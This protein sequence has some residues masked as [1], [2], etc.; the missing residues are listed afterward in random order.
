MIFRKLIF[1]ILR[2]LKI[3][4]YLIALISVTLFVLYLSNRFAKSIGS[5]EI[6]KV[7]FKYKLSKN[8]LIKLKTTDFNK[9]CDL[10]EE[11][12][13]LSNRFFFKKG[14]AF[15]I[16]EESRI[17]L[18]Y[19]TKSHFVKGL[20]LKIVIRIDNKDELEINALGYSGT[21]WFV[22]VY[23]SCV[24]DSNFNLTKIIHEQKNIDL[25][26]NLHRIKVFIFV[27]DSLRNAITNTPMELK[28]KYLNREKKKS[29]ILCAKCLYLNANEYRYLNWWIELN[30]RAGYEKIVLCNQS[31]ESNH[32][33]I[34][35]IGF[36]EIIQSYGDFIELEQLECIPNFNEDIKHYAQYYDSFKMLKMN[37]HFNG[38]LVETINIIVLGE[39]YL[40]NI[41]KYEYIGV[42]D[43]DETVL[44]KLSNQFTSIS[45][46]I[47]LI[48]SYKNENFKQSPN[49]M[50]DEKCNRFNQS[51]HYIYTFLK[52]IEKRQ[53]MNGR[54]FYFKQGYLISFKMSLHILDQI[55]DY[56]KKYSF[57]GTRLLINVTHNEGSPSQFKFNKLMLTIA[58]KEEYDYSMGL[59][60]IVNLVIKP[61]LEE[62]KE[63][64]HKYADRFARFFIYLNNRDSLGK[65]IHST[66][67]TLDFS[68]H[69]PISYLKNEKIEYSEIANE[70]GYL[71]HFRKTFLKNFETMSVNDLHLDLNYF[72]CY[73]KPILES[74]FKN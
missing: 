10:K 46:S 74:S 63:I 34:Y 40:N 22:D 32:K 49:L 60:N 69:Q 18:F 57:N 31:L 26:K 52:D 6:D 45:K 24:Y 17:R 65:T 16:I 3:L 37:G 47:K 21:P 4:Y 48:K 54:S 33:N 38:L 15:Y 73:F 58:D 27:K 50:S 71:S 7:H 1:S 43:N 67:S 12:I 20:K 68:V 25:I 14:A 30:Q 66:R 70:N 42:F 19:L 23:G 36:S 61:F 11:W 62:K 72:Y 29:A 55:S 9:Y 56:L 59:V 13:N 64:I 2:K 41:D 35:P 44:P 39:C 5:N 53:Q 28:L 51:T 8:E